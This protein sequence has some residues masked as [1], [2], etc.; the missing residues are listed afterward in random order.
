MGEISTR[1]IPEKTGNRLQCDDGGIGKHLNFASSPQI[2]AFKT[3]KPIT[4]IT[5]TQIYNEVESI[6]FKL[7]TGQSKPVGQLK[8]IRVFNNGHWFVVCLF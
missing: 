6:V 4:I 8:G 7:C 1:G 5:K 2:P 3:I